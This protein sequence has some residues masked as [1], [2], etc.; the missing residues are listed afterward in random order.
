MMW[1]EIKECYLQI[2]E[3]R[4]SRDWGIEIELR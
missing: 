4:E 3:R 2:I 1:C